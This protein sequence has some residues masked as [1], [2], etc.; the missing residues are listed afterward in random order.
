MMACGVL[1][2]RIG[3]TDKKT[4]GAHDTGKSLDHYLTIRAVC[5]SKTGENRGNYWN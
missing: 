5:S 4:D 2:M 3:R 1:L